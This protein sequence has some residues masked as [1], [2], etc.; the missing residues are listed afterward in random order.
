[1][2][3]YKLTNNINN[4]IYVGQTTNSLEKRFSWH[5][6]PSALKN[7]MLIS[8]AINKYG[9]ESFKTEILEEC[10]SIDQMNKREVYWIRHLDSGNNKVGYN[11]KLGGFNFLRSESLKAKICAS[12]QASEK[13]K[14]RKI[15]NKGLTIA[16]SEKL[17]K[18]GEAKRSKKQKRSVSTKKKMSLARKG[19]TYEEIYGENA[20]RVKQISSERMLKRYKRIILQINSQTNEIV[21]RFVSVTEALKTFGIH[22]NGG[23]LAPVLLG[24]KKTYK[25]YKWKE[26]EVS[27]ES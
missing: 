1:M 8:K 6:A 18:I 22:R 2:L 21:N 20:N 25:G 19:K 5:C 15:W 9:R 3:I 27:F 14:N 23:Q 16:T 17:R 11:I 7:N 12:L 13:F 10:L 26:V 24:R 4:K